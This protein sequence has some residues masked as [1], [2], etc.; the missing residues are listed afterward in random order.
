MKYFTWD[1]MYADEPK[2]EKE[3][4]EYEE[5]FR[6]R[7]EENEANFANAKKAFSIESL[8]NY[9]K[10]GRFH[11][12]EIKSLDIYTNNKS[13]TYPRL[14]VK[15]VLSGEN[16]YTIYYKGVSNFEMVNE[17][18]ND[19]SRAVSRWYRVDEYLYDEFDVSENGFYTHDVLLATGSTLK[20]KFRKILIKE[21][22]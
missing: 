18:D 2:N 8:R 4:R 15:V 9:E 11:D 20:V 19:Y 12:Y 14:E 1:F 22:K 21:I 10:S 6:F 3:K 13:N 16:Q 17:I 5:E 7:Q